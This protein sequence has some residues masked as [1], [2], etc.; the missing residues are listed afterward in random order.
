MKILVVE[1][2]PAN[3]KLARLVL[4]AEG[5]DVTEAQAVDKAV[6][7]IRRRAPEAILLDLELSGANGLILARNLK[8][9]PKTRHIPIVALTAFPDRFSRK[10]A[11]EAGCDGYLLK[12]ISTRTLPQQM[13]EL[14]QSAHPQNASR[15]EGARCGE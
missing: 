7:A 4:A 6:A 3:L 14:V 13:A 12:P 5:H 9:D 11:L 8:R 10:A 1:D 2:E 15:G